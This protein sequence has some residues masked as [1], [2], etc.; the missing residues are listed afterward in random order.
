[1]GIRAL[2]GEKSSLMIKGKR[3]LWL[4]LLFVMLMTMS[5]YADTEEISTIS[6]TPSESPVSVSFK[7][8]HFKVSGIGNSDGTIISK[9]YNASVSITA[10]NGEK[11][12]SVK[13][14]GDIDTAINVCE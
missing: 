2:F 10:I 6:S 3:F 1:M 14:F 12:T 8:D 13:L 9:E 4:T 11:I 7:G 5:I